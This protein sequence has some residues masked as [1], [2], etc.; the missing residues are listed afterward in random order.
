MSD[1]RKSLSGIAFSSQNLPRSAESHG[2]I[3]SS[4]PMRALFAAL[5]RIAAAVTPLLIS[6]ERGSGK[7]LFARAVHSLSDRAGGPFVTVDCTAVP[8]RQV[9]AALGAGLR[10]ADEGTLVLTGIGNLS[11][12]LQARL[13]RALRAAET[14][15]RIISTTDTDLEQAV[16]NGRFREA[17]YY[18]LNIQS[19]R[20]PPL[21]DRGRDVQLLADFFLGKFTSPGSRRRI[22]GFSAEARLA[23]QQ[24]SWP[25]NVR[26]LVNRVRK[27]IVMCSKGP[28]YSSDLD[29]DFDHRVHG[30][31][32]MTL[33]EARD[34]AELSALLTALA[35]AN[36]DIAVA[37][38]RLET[39]RAGLCRL[40]Q[41]HR[42]DLTSP[43]LVVDAER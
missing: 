10:S 30:Q 18:Q 43:Q 5:P 19:I 24:W 2:M 31:L 32:V 34:A 36:G 11:V 4:T 27:A 25:G 29:L 3:G 15:V 28:L 33:D 35:A 40:M 39:S 38:E 16:E 21:R 13:L 6:G 22:V 26:E 17:L 1:D 14:D 23:M 42:I 20:V 37:A 12:D 7:T 8:E 41:K 9:R